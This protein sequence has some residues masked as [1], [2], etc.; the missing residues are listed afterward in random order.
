MFIRKACRLNTFD[1]GFDEMYN[2]IMYNSIQK[3][4]EIKTD[5]VVV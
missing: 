4:I 5:L 3:G 2:S 1:L